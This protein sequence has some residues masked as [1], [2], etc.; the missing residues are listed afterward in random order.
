MTIE[1][2]GCIY[3]GYI[4]YEENAWGQGGDVQLCEIDGNTVVWGEYDGEGMR[5]GFT[6]RNRD[7][8]SFYP[9]AGQ[10]LAGC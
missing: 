7:L 3:F 4:R 1:G 2:Y 10:H 9:R 6:G 8:G 5:I